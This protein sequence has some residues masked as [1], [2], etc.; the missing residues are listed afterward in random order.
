[1]K[2]RFTRLT[3]LLTIGAIASASGLHAQEVG[4]YGF[5][6]L[7]ASAR[8]AALG[9]TNISIVEPELPLA[10]QNPALLCAEMADQAALSYLNYIGDINVGYAGYAGKFM[11]RGA[12][13]ASVKYVNYGHFDGYDEFGTKTG[14][15][16]AQDIA[17]N[18]GVGHAINDYWSIGGT[19]RGIYTHYESYS[20]FALGVDVGL[21][22]YNEVS[23][24]SISMTLTNL[25][26]QLKSLTEDHRNHLPTQLNIGWTKDLEHL[27]FNMTLTA[28]D[29]LDW[30]Q[31]YRDDMGEE[32]KFSGGEQILNHLLL[33]AEWL[34]T[35]N[36]WI[37]A[38]YNYRRQRLYSG[39]GGWLRG[40][41]LG[42][43]LTYR[44]LNLQCSYA[45][46]NAAD[47]SLHIGL[48]YSF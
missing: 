27:P 2:S 24:R 4:E 43:G 48:S 46:Y 11:S 14:A 20:A 45:R 41:S 35:E 1:M 16:S 31:N 13:L 19:L 6:N 40:V 17:F 5:L 39:M 33:G 44:Q 18:F 38:S 29:L 15:F 26:G 47:G 21:N 36:F 28:Y 23:G 37:A 12:W 10:D 9:G 30:D 25:G 32:H 8:A 22:Y 34:P 7:P 42:A 3:S